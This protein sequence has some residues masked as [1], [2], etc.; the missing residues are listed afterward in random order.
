MLRKISAADHSLIGGTP[1]S[2]AAM[3]RGR[4]AG[5]AVGLRRGD[6]AGGLP[7]AFDVQGQK[8]KAS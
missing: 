1:C 7:H 3:T 4:S 5:V 8:R 6:R 2:S